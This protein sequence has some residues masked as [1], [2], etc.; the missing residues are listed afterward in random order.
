M[1]DDQLSIHLHSG[2]PEG[3]TFDLAPPASC[4]WLQ[5]EEE[6]VSLICGC[7]FIAPGIN[8]T[9]PA[10]EMLMDYKPSRIWP[11]ICPLRSG[12]GAQSVHTEHGEAAL[13]C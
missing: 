9:I 3:R 6:I 11:E 5:N 4:W 13:S 1:G 7:L 8:V 10:N 12:S 2:D